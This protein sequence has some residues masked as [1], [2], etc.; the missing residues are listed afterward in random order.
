MSKGRS[1][2]L[3]LEEMVLDLIGQIYARQISEIKRTV[4][5]INTLYTLISIGNNF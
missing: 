4:F 1:L 2:T 3:T 5:I